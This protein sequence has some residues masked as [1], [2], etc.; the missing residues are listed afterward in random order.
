MRYGLVLL[1]VVFLVVQ[2]VVM[3]HMNPGKEAAPLVNPIGTSTKAGVSESAAVSVAPTPPGAK[4]TNPVLGKARLRGRVL[5]AQEK[6][7]AGVTVLVDRRALKAGDVLKQ[8]GVGPRWKTQTDREGAFFFEHLSPNDGFVVSA[9]TPHAHAMQRVYTTAHGVIPEV[10]LQLQP[11]LVFS[12]QVYDS[13]EQ[14]VKNARVYPVVATTEDFARSA[15]HLLPVRTHVDGAFSFSHLSDTPWR[16]LIVASPDAPL[17]TEPLARTGASL[18]IHLEEGASLSGRIVDEDTKKPVAR[19]ELL[20]TESE[21]GLE[22]YRAKTDSAGRFT[23]QNLRAARYWI[24][25]RSDAYALKQAPGYFSVDRESAPEEHILAVER[26][27]FI[28]GRV[29]DADGVGVANAKA[30][31]HMDGERVDYT[32][33]AGYFRL[34]G[35][36]PGEYTVFVTPPEGYAQRTVVHEATVLPSRQTMTPDTQVVAGVSAQGKV[37]DQSGTPVAAA[38]VYV[39]LS[40]LVSKTF[41]THTDEKGVFV[42]S[43]LPDG[44]TTARFRAR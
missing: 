25:L 13:L 28:R 5:D 32:D 19:M 38:N 26:A 27:G 7:V 40:L 31:T 18:S 8:A 2:F 35:L 23:F 39:E 4:A 1:I 43:D 33:Q 6:P 37:Y 12:G 15:Y 21:L 24:T 34:S 42:F 11:S 9:V 29:L 30:V 20:A 44:D 36:R 14:P 3:F 22:Y 41:S 10:T 16:F 17:L